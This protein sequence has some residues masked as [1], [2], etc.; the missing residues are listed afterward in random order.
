M[1]QRAHDAPPIAPPVDRS[2]VERSWR[3]RG[4]SCGL[5]VDPP[6]QVWAD[7]VH[8]V[9]E[10]VMVLEGEVE[11]E[12]EGKAYRPQPGEELFIPARARHTVRNLGP[13]ASR[14]LYGYRR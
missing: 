2:A 5:W 10:L 6:G 4:F 8:D 9:D 3:E 13:G 11:F 12:I 1:T 7:Y 14:W